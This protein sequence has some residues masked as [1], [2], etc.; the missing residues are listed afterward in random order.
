MK[1]TVVCAKLGEQDQVV[2]LDEGATAQ[3][4][5]DATI[6]DD[7]SERALVRVNRAAATMDTV[8]HEHDWVTFAPT[9]V[10]FAG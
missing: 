5:Y 7:Q 3:D 6:D 2:E 4:A 1:V 8:L 10:P 9:E